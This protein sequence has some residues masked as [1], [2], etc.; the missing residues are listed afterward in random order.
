MESQKWFDQGLISRQQPVPEPS[1]AEQRRLE[2]IAAR[3]LAEAFRHGQL[4][5]AL[6]GIQKA[7]PARDGFLWLKPHPA[8]AYAVV[9]RL[10]P[11]N[12]RNYGG[13][14]GVPGLRPQSL[15][16]GSLV[17]ADVLSTAGLII[18]VPSDFSLRPVSSGHDGDNYDAIWHIDPNS[19]DDNERNYLRSWSRIFD[20][21]GARR[22][23]LVLSR[24]L[25]RPGILRQIATT[26]GLANTWSHW[27]RDIVIEWCC[28]A[29]ESKAKLLLHKSGFTKELDG[30]EA[31]SHESRHRI[32][33]GDTGLDLRYSSHYI[34]EYDWVRNISA[35][36]S[37]DEALGR[38]PLLHCNPP[39]MRK[40]TP[41]DLETMTL[42]LFTKM[43]LGST[44][45]SSRDA[46]EDFVM[47]DDSAEHRACLV[48]VKHARSPLGTDVV[49]SLANR[50]ARS[51]AT[52]GILV[53]TGR[54][55][56]SARES[57]V[58]HEQI[59]LI[60][61]DGLVEALAEHLGIGLAL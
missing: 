5:G 13:L 34:P 17:L 33:W 24:L 30:V 50:V 38:Y 31:D 18:R 20:D 43:G 45:V 26:H 3:E 58:R 8:M 61:G 19:A 40:I 48:R 35:G 12:D 55:T 44:S 10:L 53:T 59:R 52:E 54:F 22:R 41:A 25:R 42:A 39:N 49:H 28:G 15:E 36:Y 7:K 2:A 37:I 14:R 29:T 51:G 1:T 32:W 23:D 47:T 16:D 60:D 21:A 4:D 6:L 9:H 11:Y 56:A 46:G 27:P 57:S